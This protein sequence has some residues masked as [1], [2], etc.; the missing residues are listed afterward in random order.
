MTR[1][2]KRMLVCIISGI[3]LLITAVVISKCIKLPWYGELC[4]FLIP[5][6]VSGGDVLWRALENIFRGQI[7]DENFLMSIAT[8]GAFVIHDYPEASFVMLFYKIGELFENIAVGKSRKSI[9]E[10]MNIRPDSATVLRGE[11]EIV[12][13]PEEV[14]AGEILLVKPGEKIPL[15]GFILD[16]NTTV[17]NAALTGESLPIECGVGD[18]VTSGSVNLSGVIRIKAEGTYSESTVAKILDLVENTSSRKAES[19]NFITKFARYYTPCVVFVALLLALV[20][21]LFFHG[22]WQEWLER[23][24]IFLVVSCPCALVISVPLSFF[25]GIGGASHYGILIKGSNYLEALAKVK[26]IVFDKTGTLTKGSFTVT[27]LHAFS[28]SEEELLE[29]AAFVESYSNHPIAESIVK[30]YGREIDKKRIQSIDEISGYGIIADVDGRRVC[31]GN[32][33]LMRREGIHVDDDHAEGTVVH[34]VSDGKY[35]GYLVISDE[36]KDGASE[37][38][39]ALYRCGVNKTV[40]LTGDHDAV[41]QAVGKTLGIREVHT[42]LLP[43]DKVRIVEQLISESDGS[44]VFVGDGMNDAPVLSRADVGIAMGALGSDAAIE[45]A[46]VILMDDKLSKVARAIEISKKTLAVV[47]QN[48]IFALAVKGMILIFGALGMMN[49][50][51]AIF[52]DVGVAVIAILNAMRTLNA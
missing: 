51:I 4:L 16:G 28:M 6:L 23:A 50:W 42:E 40:M 20:P 46:D 7:F 44:L 49:M 30:A 13:S 29:I 39:E 32:S 12:L 36:I 22:I 3:F 27:S 35:A 37:A 2:Q 33:K 14:E 38:I 15:D 26:T 31:V 48:I 8:I 52:G 47:Y 17:N 41:G 25:G 5:Y 10:L 43:A 21:P 18:T 19:E 24:L 1:K 34:I 11:E 9:A 45:A